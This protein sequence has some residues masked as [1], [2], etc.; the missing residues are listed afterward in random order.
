MADLK[1]EFQ[2]L[3][4]SENQKTFCGIL[5]YFGSASYLYQGMPMGLDISAAVWQTYM[6]AILDC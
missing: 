6:S 3:R 2:S 5:Q 1:D 4:L